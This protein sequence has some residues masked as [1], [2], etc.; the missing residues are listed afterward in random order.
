MKIAVYTIC[1]NE[2]K[3]IKKWAESAKDADY[4]ILV[5]TGSTDN[6][7]QIAKDA[8]CTV[9]TVKISPWRFDDARNVSLS[10]VPEDADLCICLDA[11][12]ILIEG[13]RAHLEALPPEVNRPRYKYT[14][15]WNDDGSPGLTYSGDKIHARFGFRWRHPVHEVITAAVPEV[16]QFCGM[17]I[18]HHADNAK[19]RSQYFPL[20]EL[21]AREQPTCDRTAHYLAREYFFHGRIEEAV[22]EFKRHITME[23]ALWPAEK[24][25]SMRY[26]AQCEPHNAESWLLRALSED[27]NRRETWADL[28][29]HYYNHNRWIPCFASAIRGLEISDNTD[30]YMVESFAWGYVLYDMAAI[31]SYRLGYYDKALE[32][33]ILALEKA[34]KDQRLLDNLEYYKDGKIDTDRL[35]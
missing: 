5:D 34:P 4:R 8:G 11:D 1:L 13:W 35:E 29:T 15:S 22:R 32:Y 25:R 3:H 7:V 33:G 30:D 12:E 9:H 20:L 27:P 28:S 21:A 18:H 16:Q 24:A 31:S 23:T 26:L 2:E 19:P 10:L 6:T 17:E 14:W